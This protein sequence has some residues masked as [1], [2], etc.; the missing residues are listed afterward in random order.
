MDSDFM[1]LDNVVGELL[2]S[3]RHFV[4]SSLISVVLISISIGC[5]GGKG[6]SKQYSRRKGG[7]RSKKSTTSR[8]TGLDSRRKNSD[9]LDRDDQMEDTFDF[10]Q[11]KMEEAKRAKDVSWPGCHSS[12]TLKE[13]ASPSSSQPHLLACLFVFTAK[14]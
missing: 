6:G 14:S 9:M 7:G 4:I 10:H 13:F 1:I 12:S 8:S 11:P 2:G 3:C 5:C